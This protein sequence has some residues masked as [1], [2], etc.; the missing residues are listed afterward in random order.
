MGCG[1][2]VDVKKPYRCVGERTSGWRVAFYGVYGWPEEDQKF[3]TGML[4]RQ[5]RDQ[6]AGPWLCGG[7]FNMMS[8]SSEKQGGKEFRVREADIFRQAVDG[9]NFQDLGYLGHDFTWKNNRGGEDNVQ[10]R[11]D[12]VFATPLWRN[13]F[14]GSF[15]THLSKRKSDHL[16]ILLCMKGDI[17][18]PKTKKKRRLY[19]FETMW[20]RDE[21]CADIVATARERCGDICS[22]IAH[23]SG[24]LSAW[25]RK[26]FGD[27]AKELKDCRGRMEELMSEP[28]TANII[29]EM[30]AL[31]D[32]MDKL[33][34]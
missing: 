27:F 15:V 14:P 29:A 19:R 7:Y 32:R 20:L 11:L 1:S 34:T 23:T 4:L 9:C 12:S 2:I 30:K 24:Q 28:Q 33:E 16:P 6:C 21:G 13:F 8:V 22:K 17:N 3:K 25:G 31:D 5:L 18:A 10:E 26:K